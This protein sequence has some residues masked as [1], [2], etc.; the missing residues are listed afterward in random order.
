MHVTIFN[1]L[2][3]VLNSF[4]AS[5]L[6]FCLKNICFLSTSLLATKDYVLPQ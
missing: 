3:E 6:N 1:C 5:A 4:K 2:F